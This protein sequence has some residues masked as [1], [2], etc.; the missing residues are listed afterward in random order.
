MGE[1]SLNLY[2]RDSLFELLVEQL[3]GFVVADEEGRYVFVSKRWSEMTG[4][5]LEDIKGMY[6][7]DVVSDSRVDQVLR[8]GLP[9][10]GEVVKLRTAYG[11]ELH[12][13]CSYTP[14]YEE[15]RLIG[16]FTVSSLHGMGEMMDF[17]SKMEDLI[18]T[19]NHYH[20]ELVDI[21]GAKYSI[22]NIIGESQSIQQLKAAIYK[23]ARSASTVI[24]QG[25]TGTGKELVAH[26]IHALSARA[27]QPFIKINCAAIPSELLESELFGYA[28]GAFTGAS[29]TGKKGKFQLADQ[30]TLF[31]DEI[32][33]LPLHLQSKLLRVLQEHEVEPVG[34]TRS[35]PVD[36]RII[37]ASNVSL[38]KL[39]KQGA[40][41][42]D[43]FYRLNVLSLDVPPLRERKEDIPLIADALLKRLNAKLGM[44]VPGISQEAKERLKEY[45]WPGN[46]RELQNVIERAMNLSWADTLTWTH[47]SDY[48]GRRLTAGGK[49]ASGAKLCTLRKAKGD[50]EREVILSADLELAEDAAARVQADCAGE[51]QCVTTS[52]G[53]ELRFPATFLVET[54]RRRERLYI[55][56]A[57]WEEESEEG[58]Q[59][60]VVLEHLPAGARLWDVAKRRHSTCADILAANGLEKEEDID[61]ERLLLIPRR[62]A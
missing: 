4:L 58:T 31:L 41:R 2:S 26:S 32:N 13:L 46:V 35:V 16:C 44:G 39:V 7:R 28:P 25:E 43:L 5:S 8:D 3:D 21:Q 6:V 30:G 60:S 59:P 12:L 34:G 10:S 55:R 56:E 40:F 9:R 29:R 53:V 57:A 14:L 27:P 1:G 48:F 38:E 24:I 37:A 11:T 42:E 33:Q 62:R 54:C 52:D 15:G 18:Q 50:A 20:R 45:D 47:F 36:C 23:A 22:S 17:S 51:I 49:A 61:G 19:L